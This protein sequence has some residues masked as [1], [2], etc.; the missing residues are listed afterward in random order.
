MTS[1]QRFLTALCGG[2]PD[3]LP[4]TTQWV[5]GAFLQNVAHLDEQVFYDRF[6]LDP[7]L[8][9]APHRCRYS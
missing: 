3:R 4:V 8:Y 2:K 6:G 1:R 5:H 9:L 7:I